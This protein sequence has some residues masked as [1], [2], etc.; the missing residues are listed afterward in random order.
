MEFRSVADIDRLTREW[1][2]SLPQDFDLLVGI[3]QGGMLVAGLLAWHLD[4]PV[5]DLKGLCEG[6]PDHRDEVDRALTGKRK[7][8]VVDDRT[9]T[10]ESLAQAKV[11]IEAAGLVH[12]IHFGAAIAAPE[13][14]RNGATDL[15]AETLPTPWL[16]EWDV[17][18]SPS[19]SRMCVHFESVLAPDGAG[20]PSVFPYDEIGWIVTSRSESRRFETETWLRNRGIA[21]TELLMG[22]TDLAEVCRNLEADMLVVY[23]AS[24]ASRIARS[25]SNPVFSIEA[26]ATVNSGDS[27]QYRYLEIPSMHRVAGG[28]RRLLHSPL[29]MAK[30][31][32]R[33]IF[34]GSANP[35]REKEIAAGD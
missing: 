33:A 22:C 25:A 8:L 2:G 6:R 7:I 26:G 3:S 4:L 19:S 35:E 14:V 5:T 16:F 23:S 30:K 24:H 21:Y 9:C 10:G 27:L 32:S 1:A 15:F 18:H 34:G 29:R 17:M 11:R 20:A 12:E 13:A 31:F 28:P